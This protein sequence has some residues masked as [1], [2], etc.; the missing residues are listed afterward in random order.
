M[1][2]PEVHGAS[3]EIGGT[4]SGTGTPDPRLF[5]NSLARGLM[6]LRAYGDGPQAMTIAEVAVATGLGRSAAQRFVYTLEHLH[7]LQRDRVTR[8][9]RLTPRVLELA[10]GFLHNDPLV[11]HAARVLSEIAHFSEEAASLSELDDLHIVVLSR[12]PSQHL[13]SVNVVQGMRFPAWCSAPGRA[14]LAHRPPAQVEDIIE[15]S[16]LEAITGHTIT[17]R[18]RLL[19]AID[20]VR[21]LGYSLAVEELF[22]GTLSIA[23]PVLG[24][25]GEPL[26]AI[27]LF[28]PTARWPPERARSELAPLL[29]TKAR[30]LSQ[31]ARP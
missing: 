28:C 16:R 2:Q 23:A 1:A 29:I 5:V 24:E 3:N 25:L 13:F 8:A 4:T 12:V 15:R 31:A 6:V 19:V 17:D 30:E 10:Y 7:L 27:N 11:E 18:A 21:E 14:M 9:Y 22:L 20:V 26:A